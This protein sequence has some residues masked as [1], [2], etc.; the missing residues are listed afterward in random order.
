M[1]SARNNC[2]KRPNVLI[3]HTDQQR[4][5]SLGC[6]GNRHAL[7]P[8]IDRL[9]TEGTLFHR[10]VTAHPVCMPSRASFFTGRYPNASGVY[11]NGIALP[12]R[13]HMTDHPMN[14]GQHV[15]TEAIS[16]VPTMPDAFSDAGYRTA[17]IGKLH[18]TCT[19]GPR[20]S[21]YEESRIR[22]SEEDMTAWSGPY[23]GFDQA[24]LT[25]GHGEDYTGHY[26]CWLRKT[27]PEVAEKVRSGSFRGSGPT[28]WTL[29]PS[30]V[31]V[32]AHS[33]TWIADRAIAYLNSAADRDEPFFLF[34]GFPDPHFPFTPPAELAER[35][36]DR[37]TMAWQERAGGSGGGIPSPLRKLYQE[38]A[39]QNAAR[40][41]DAFVREARRYTDAMIHLID[42]S[43]GRIQDALR[44]SELEEDTILVY[45]SDHGDYLGD[46]G[47][48]FKANY[49]CKALNH[50]PFI[51]K[52]PKKLAEL[53][54]ECHAAMSNTDVMPTLGDLA[55]V[56]MPDGVQGRSVIP[57][58]LGEAGSLPVQVTCY[59]DDPAGHNFS[60]WNDRYRYTWYPATGECELYDHET[61]PYETNNIAGTPQAAD[62]E[63]QMRCDLLELHC[64]TDRPSLGKSAHW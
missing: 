21:R 15:Q 42:V 55:G 41:G 5:D 8:H 10:H 13:M 53:P 11:A 38:E 48:V 19:N 60:L 25:I 1:K 64:L 39:L 2:R 58:L 62:V 18:F 49:G 59:D 63:R 56:P 14:D 26:G 9:A 51:M 34:L 30:V 52:V 46:Y 40:Y 6:T 3:I 17:A 43:V 44:Q 47:L 36:Q 50:V 28:K 61:D 7:T 37:D 24:E 4:Y 20:S 35:F 16:H 22:W 27:Y 23:Y 12:R 33:S 29:Y 32:E 45:T 57:L 31:P 54:K